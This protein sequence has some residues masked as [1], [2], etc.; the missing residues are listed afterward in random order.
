MSLQLEGAE[1]LPV[2][3]DKQVPLLCRAEEAWQH[4]LR[5]LSKDCCV[6]Q[7]ALHKQIAQQGRKPVQV[8]ASGDLGTTALVTATTGSALFAALTPT[9]LPEVADSA[10]E[11]RVETRRHASLQTRTMLM[12]VFAKRSCVA[13]PK[14]LRA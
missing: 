4:Y 3:D 1:Q 13:L 6:G 7:A 2:D 8:F 11:A 10:S 9:R 12:R 5:S 14:R